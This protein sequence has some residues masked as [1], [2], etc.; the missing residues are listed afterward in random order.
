MK[1]CFTLLSTHCLDYI[2]TATSEG[3]DNPFIHVDLKTTRHI[4]ERNPQNIQIYIYLS[5]N[6]NVITYLRAVY[7]VSNSW[8]HL[9]SL[10]ERICHTIHPFDV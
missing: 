7:R 9:I 1:D 5:S 6:A 3:D 8:L 4:C 10:D 2:G